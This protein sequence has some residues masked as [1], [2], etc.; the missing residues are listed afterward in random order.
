MMLLT[1][2]VEE[3]LGIEAA[4]QTIIDEIQYT[5]SSHGMTIDD[6]HV[7]LLADVMTSKGMVL[8]EATGTSLRSFQILNIVLLYGAETVVDGP[9]R[10]R[11]HAVRPGQN[12]GQCSDVGVFRE[13]C[14]PPV[15]S[16][17]S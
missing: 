8:G 9:K 11:Y 15:R 12:E 13:D 5:M 6:R 4:R 17:K 2:K 1:P 16:R 14:W 7:M 3:V 10:S